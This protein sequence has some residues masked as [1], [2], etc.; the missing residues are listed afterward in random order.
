MRSTA[1]RYNKSFK[2]LPERPC[3]NLESIFFEMRTRT[4]RSIW[5][6]Y[7]HVQLGKTGEEF[8]FRHNYFNHCSRFSLKS[9]PR[10]STCDAE[11]LTTICDCCQP[12][13]RRLREFSGV[14]DN[15][16]ASFVHIAYNEVW[17]KRFRFRTLEMNSVWTPPPPGCSI[18]ELNPPFTC[19]IDFFITMTLKELPDCTE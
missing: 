15:T 12:P 6:V 19:S 3:S 17:T 11:V 1:S 18:F 16:V 4:N 14:Y 5:N 8:I 2:M 7:L 9:H 13:W 10:Q